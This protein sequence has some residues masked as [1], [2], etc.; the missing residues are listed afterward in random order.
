MKKTRAIRNWRT[1]ANEIWAIINETNRTIQETNEQMKKSNEAAERR[2][3]ENDRQIGKLG[4]R[5]GEIIEYMVAPD[6][7]EKFEKLGL[8]FEKT[9]KDN[10]FKDK[11]GK[12]LFEVDILLEN[13]NM[14]LAIEVKS[15]P[16]I[17][18][19]CEHTERLA[20]MR[21]FSDSKGDNRKFM[22]AIAGAVVTDDVRNYALKHGFF[23]IEPS[24]EIFTILQ[25]HG[26][27]RE[28]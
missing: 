8:T 15:K 24:G 12:F 4:N 19:V 25:P 2:I 7:L 23:V 26:K 28:W 27:P 11:D 10:L 1:A 3:K 14:A 6:L 13:T 21:I 5:L 9:S 20:K 17:G 22:A 16:T 18:D